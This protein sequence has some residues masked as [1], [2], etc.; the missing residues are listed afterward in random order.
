VDEADRLNAD[1]NSARLDQAALQHALQAQGKTWHDLVK[2]RCSYLFATVPVF[3]S[4]TQ[5]RKMYEVI[6]AVEK[7]VALAGWK[8]K[9]D[10]I[11]PIAKG[12]FFGY[13]FHLD[14]QGVHLIEIN[15]NAGGA[16][17]NQILVDSQRNADLP[18]KT[19]A[20]ENLEASIL[21]M[22]RNEWR[23]ERG[24]APIKTVAIVDQQPED[25]YLYP[26]F[27]LAKKWIENAGIAVHIADPSTL[28]LREDGLH[29]GYE[30]I[31]MVYNRLTDF[32]LQKFPVLRQAY[33][34]GRVV[35]TPHPHAYERYADKRNLTRL[36]DVDGLRSLG[37]NEDDI[38]VLYAGIP[39]TFAVQPDMEEQL[40]KERKQWFFKPGSG[41]GG[42]GA[43]NGAK[44]TRRV[45]GEILHGDYVAQKLVQP[46][47]RA[48][49]V[50]DAGAAALKY[51]VRCYV[52][53]GQIQLVAARLYQ[54]QTTNFRTPGG[55]FALVRVVE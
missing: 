21:A 10:E 14:D 8:A 44:V 16:F 4:P 6:S 3:I 45:F 13:D 15:T 50:D 46:G 12:V 17:L 41:Y 2:Q 51:D 31:D 40:W 52:Y 35:L 55:G 20:V 42:K 25:Q 7:V 1:F 26:E 24:S 19:A 33:L 23:L 36:S 29:F 53:E 48:V 43:Y 37:V 22:F 39:H 47:A 38:S 5:L 18:G 27:L 30:K 34:D 54:G 32:S 49:Y 28:Q 11:R 9:S